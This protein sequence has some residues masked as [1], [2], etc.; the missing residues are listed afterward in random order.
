MA[1]LMAVGVAG[2]VVVDDEVFLPGTELR[3]H[4]VHGMTEG[5]KKGSDNAILH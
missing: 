2:A 4:F 5:A 1:E 3:A